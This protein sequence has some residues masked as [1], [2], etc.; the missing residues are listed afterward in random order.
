MMDRRASRAGGPADGRMPRRTL[1]G[2]VNRPARAGDRSQ[3]RSRPATCSP[4]SPYGS[5][6]RSEKPKGT[7]LA[8]VA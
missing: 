8:S 2:G 6:I 5:D 3:T 1:I 4:P 7:S